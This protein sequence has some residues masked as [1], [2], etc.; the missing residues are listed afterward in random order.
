MGI[1]LKDLKP[2]TNETSVYIY[3]VQSIFYNNFHICH[4]SLNETYPYIYEI[5]V[6]NFL[7][8]ASGHTMPVSLN[9]T[10]VYI[11]ET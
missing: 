4:V 7:L 10:Y 3:E 11:Y 9:E 6:T 8:V 2:P 5:S 1:L